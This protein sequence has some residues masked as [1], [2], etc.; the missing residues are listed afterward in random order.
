MTTGD[1]HLVET[2]TVAEVEIEIQPM[3]RSIMATFNTHPMERSAMISNE[4][5]IQLD[6]SAGKHILET[7]THHMERSITAMNKHI[8]QTDS[9]ADKHF[10]ETGTERSTVGIDR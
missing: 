10:F 6:S 3:K 7:D 4:R 2:K 8:I 5:V 1:T 9:P